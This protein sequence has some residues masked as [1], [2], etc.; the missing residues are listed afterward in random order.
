MS[1]TLTLDVMYGDVTIDVDGVMC[2][3]N[4]TVVQDNDTVMV[5]QSNSESQ[6]R[7]LRL[8]TVLISEIIVRSG[9]RCEV[10]DG[11]PV[12]KGVEVCA[13]HGSY[14]GVVQESNPRISTKAADF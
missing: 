8:S 7:R 11:A 1:D 10:L 13:E 14:V 9:A 3:A 5:K 12:Q 6:V 2:S 4:A